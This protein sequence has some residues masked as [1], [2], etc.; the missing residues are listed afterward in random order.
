MLVSF[1]FHVG[2]GCFTNC[3]SKSTYL[4][5]SASFRCTLGRGSRW[6]GKGTSPESRKTGKTS[7]SSSIHQLYKLYT[8]NIVQILWSILY[9][10]DCTL[11]T[12]THIQHHRL[13][14]TP[15]ANAEE[16]ACKRTSSRQIVQGW[17]DNNT[18]KMSFVTDMKRR[19]RKERTGQ[20]RTREYLFFLMFPHHKNA[21]AMGAK[22][23]H[24]HVKEGRGSSSSGADQRGQ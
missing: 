21:P 10:Q 13:Q 12:R 7:C 22:I 1:T 11:S 16:I 9:K 19:K 2:E 5:P 6:I 14:T 3:V 15:R 4:G 24:A 18:W 23:P 8:A 20:A 17:N